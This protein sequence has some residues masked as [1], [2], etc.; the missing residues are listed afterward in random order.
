MRREEFESRLF[1]ILE[2]QSAL[3][4]LFIGSGMSRRYLRLPDWAGLLR[5][6]AEQIGAS[7]DYLAATANGDYPLIAH[8]LAEEFHAKWWTDDQFAPSRDRNR[9][10]TLNRESALKIAVSQYIEDNQTLEAGRPGVDD[11]ALASE[12]DLLRNGV[13]DGV[14][15]TN[16]DSL[17]DQL[18][19]DFKAYIGQDELMLSDAQFIAETYKIHGSASR[20][21]TLVLTSTDYE[22]FRQRGAYLAAKL[23]T[24]FAEHPVI[25][26]GYSITDEY[27]QEILRNIALAVGPTRLGRLADRLIFVERNAEGFEPE[28]GPTTM[29]IGGTGLPIL[30]IS[31]NDYSLLYGVLT[32]LQRPFPAQVLRKLREVVYNLVAERDLS[33]EAVAAIPIDAPGAEGLKVVFGVGEF[34]PSQTHQ[35]AELGIRGISRTDLGLDVLGASDSHYDAESVLTL[36]VPSIRSRSGGSGYIP[37]F[38]YLRELGRIGPGGEVDYSGMPAAV[39]ACVERISTLRLN[40]SQR[41]RFARDVEGQHSTPSSVRQSGLALY[42]QMEALLALD[43][44]GFSLDEY[45]QTLIDLRQETEGTGHEPAWWKVLCRYDYLRNGTDAP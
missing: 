16:Y 9:S 24:I 17:T 41:Q 21:S 26:L 22:A 1:S 13:I 27:I 44:A 4:Y 45:R 5:H 18:F 10:E 7:Y 42:V 20:P 11:K 31:I 19:P 23:L 6:F 30:H 15:T 14:I 3:P 37:V 38:K 33:R 2:G 29:A 12:I 8:L 25:F 39:A 43:P 28:M 36:A 35:I 32:R 40:P 34:S